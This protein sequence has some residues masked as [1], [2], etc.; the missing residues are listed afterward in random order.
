MDSA[1]RAVAIVGVGAILP[2]APSAAAY[3]ENILNQRYSISD[4]P[5]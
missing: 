5:V 2:D 4:V 3:W 1:A